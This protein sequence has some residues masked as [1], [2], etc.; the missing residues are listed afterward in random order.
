M[1]LGLWKSTYQNVV[2]TVLGIYRAPYS[3]SNKTTDNQFI[4]EF[5]NI[6]AD[7]LPHHN[8]LVIL[9]DI[10]LHLNKKDDPLIDI[11][12]QSLSALGLKQHVSEYTHKEGNILDAIITDLDTNYTHSCEVGDFLSDHR[13]VLFKTIRCKKESKHHKLEH[14]NLKCVAQS[15]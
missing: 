11:L 15:T 12:D 7:I 10:N 5:L 8:N 1:E 3:S 14:R 6:L 2:N 4:D 9:G 13:Y